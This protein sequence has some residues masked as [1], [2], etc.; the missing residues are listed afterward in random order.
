MLRGI[1]VLVACGWL[2][3]T[4]PEPAAVTAPAVDPMAVLRETS[5]TYKSASTY[6]FVSSTRMSRPGVPMGQLAAGVRPSKFRQELDTPMGRIVEV[7]DGTS[8][9][10]YFPESNEYVISPTGTGPIP[11][12]NEDL[13]ASYSAMTFLVKGARWLRSEEVTLE[14][15]PVLCDVIAVDK[16]AGTPKFSLPEGVP[17]FR[18]EWLGAPVTYWI[19]RQEHR[20]LRSVAT[21]STGETIETTFS[22]A[23]VNDEVPAHLFTFQI[24]PN[25]QQVAGVE[26]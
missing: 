22:I 16:E 24:P 12:F 1:V 3:C 21:S 9:W 5:D 10:T 26:K 4:S 20:V 6:Y 13:L 14:G 17:D 15:R 25:A 18:T 23:R 7:S 11:N 8:Q 2:G 19:D